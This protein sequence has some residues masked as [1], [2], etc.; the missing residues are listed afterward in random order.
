MKGVDGCLSSQNKV[1]GELQGALS[2]RNVHGQVEYDLAVYD[3]EY[4]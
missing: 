4:K 2:L 3:E 1:E